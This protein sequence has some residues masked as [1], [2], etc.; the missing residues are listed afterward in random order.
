MRRASVEIRLERFDLFHAGENR[1]LVRTDAGLGGVDLL[2]DRGVLAL[3]L[4]LHQTVLIV[5]P[6]FF[7]GAELERARAPVG[8][9]RVEALLDRDVLR[10]ALAEPVLGF[11]D[12]RG[13]AFNHCVGGLDLEGELLDPHELQELGSRVRHVCPPRRP[14]NTKGAREPSALS[15][16]PVSGLA[17]FFRGRPGRASLLTCLC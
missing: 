7:Q 12:L 11:V 13:R 8:V 16:F 5:L 4:H 6:G 1:L 9:D 17:P 15:A 14:K 10:V 3:V 2:E